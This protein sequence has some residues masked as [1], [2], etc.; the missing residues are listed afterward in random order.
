MW[1]VVAYT[2]K[3][4]LNNS[5]LYELAHRMTACPDLI[6][7]NNRAKMSVWFRNKSILDVWLSFFL[8]WDS[9]SQKSISGEH[10]VSL[11]GQP[12]QGISKNNAT[13]TTGQK[14]NNFII[15]NHLLCI[16]SAVYPPQLGSSSN[17]IKD[18]LNDWTDFRDDVWN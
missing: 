8:R 15:F 11:K 1:T 10:P 9:S 13:Q 12:L 2:L 7:D 3:D 5:R 17:R 16:Y 4:S 6:A 14:C 18:M